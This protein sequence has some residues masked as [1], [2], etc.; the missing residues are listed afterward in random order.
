MKRRELLLLLGWVSMTGSPGFED[1][2]FLLFC[3]PRIVRFA[4]LTKPAW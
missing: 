3:E 4:A 2:L 1:R